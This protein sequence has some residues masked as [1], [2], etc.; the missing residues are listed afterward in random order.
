M[1]NTGSMNRHL[2]QDVVVYAFAG[3]CFIGAFTRLTHGKFLPAFYE[4][5][6]DHAPDDG[7][8]QAKAIPLMDILIGLGT[9]WRP[10]KLLALILGTFFVAI[11]AYFQFSSGKQ[12][13]LD[14]SHLA[15]GLQAIRYTV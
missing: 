5:Q 8:I 6:I 9:L 15:L 7:S 14:M 4:Y 11:G 2:I 10:T 3:I 1:T 12:Y 13:F